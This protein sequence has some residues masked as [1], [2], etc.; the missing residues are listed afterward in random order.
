[1]KNFD[2]LP[3]RLTLAR[4]LA[5]PLLLILF[6]WDIKFLNFICALIFAAAA[7]TDFLDG[8]LARKLGVTSSLGA[9]LDP[10]ADKML[11]AASIIMLSYRGLIWP[12]LA[13]TMICRDLAV[14]GIRLSALEKGITLPVDRF[15]KW[16]TIMQDAGIFG[17]MM[18]DGSFDVPWRSLGT[19][20]MWIAFVLSI[21]S[22]YRYSVT[23]LEKT[24]ILKNH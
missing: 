7:L 6:P 4:V 19:T 14:N 17:L 3:N 20:A 18:N 12:L 21:Y 5:I 10:I 16:K 15:G 1:M 2:S 24:G 9:L 22:A 23:F 11:V 13:A 8:Y